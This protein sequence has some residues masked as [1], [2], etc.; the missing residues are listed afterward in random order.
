MADTLT[1]QIAARV[2]P[3]FGLTP[4]AVALALTTAISIGANVYQHMTAF[5]KGWDSYETAV[6]DGTAELDGERFEIMTKADQ[7]ALASKAR[8]D[9]ILEMQGQ[10]NGAYQFAIQGI[11]NAHANNVNKPLPPLAVDAVDWGSTDVPDSERL[12]FD[13]FDRRRANRDSDRTDT[14]TDDRTV[15]SG[16][17]TDDT[18]STRSPEHGLAGARTNPRR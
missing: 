16:Y 13:A 15:P 4:T 1:G 11:N 2:A 6:R 7:D 9:A 5:D 8:S 17:P 12:R 14:T 3:R 10:I 18:T